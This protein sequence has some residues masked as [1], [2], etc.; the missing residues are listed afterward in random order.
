MK[1]HYKQTIVVAET[2]Q[3]QSGLKNTLTLIA[4]LKLTYKQKEK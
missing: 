2:S 3:D 1:K 4:F